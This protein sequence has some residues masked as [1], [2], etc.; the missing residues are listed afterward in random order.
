MFSVIKGSRALFYEEEER[1]GVDV[2]RVT[3][4]PAYAVQ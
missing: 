3:R 1:K 2:K 4:D